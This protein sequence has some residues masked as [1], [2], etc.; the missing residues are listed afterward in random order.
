MN[1]VSQDNEQL[2]SEKSKLELRREIISS[3]IYSYPSLNIAMQ[4]IN[5][6]SL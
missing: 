1:S 5:T 6:Y 4:L 2:F 3:N